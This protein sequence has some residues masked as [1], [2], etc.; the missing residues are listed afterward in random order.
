MRWEYSW[1]QVQDGT[2]ARAWKARESSSLFL[3]WKF[4]V[5]HLCF[6]LSIYLT[7][8]SA[9]S[10][11]LLLEEN[12]PPSPLNVL[13]FPVPSTTRKESTPPNGESQKVRSAGSAS[14]WTASPQRAAPL[15]NGFQELT[16]KSLWISRSL[17]LPSYLPQSTTGWFSRSLPRSCSHDQEPPRSPHSMWA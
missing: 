17:G 15:S 8:L 3:F 16:P 12:G 1:N 2:G 10:V 14:Q 5:P 13:S 4:L 6:S 7:F 9:D 11:S